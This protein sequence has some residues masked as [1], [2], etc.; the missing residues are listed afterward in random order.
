MKGFLDSSVCIRIA[1]VKYDWGAVR[2]DSCFLA[3]FCFS[4]L[5]KMVFLLLAN[6]IVG[7]TLGA[8]L[9]NTL[10][11]GFTIICVCIWDLYN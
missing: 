9:K 2:L 8:A 11:A 7:Y 4:E 1:K 3:L 5:G 6:L 10:E